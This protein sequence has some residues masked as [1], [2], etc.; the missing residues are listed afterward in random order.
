MK[1]ILTVFFV[2][3]GIIFFALILFGV[4]FLITDPYDLKPIFFGTG[5]AESIET[6]SSEEEMVPQA[7][8]TKENTV[9]TVGTQSSGGF[10]LT[11]AQKEALAS[12][13]IDP[14]SISTTITAE[15]EACFVDVLGAPRVA[16]IRNG[17]VPSGFEFVRAQSC[18]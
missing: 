6:Q 1:K 10:E 17:A 11:A 18:I 7:G 8:E 5:A 16:E 3:L 4:Y 2:T 9:D 15:Q 13:G 12:Y 14:N